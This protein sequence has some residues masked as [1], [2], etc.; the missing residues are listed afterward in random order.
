MEETENK[1][2]LSKYGKI[3]GFLALEILA[4][5]AFGLGNSFIFVSI[6]SFILL[7]VS[8]IV[9]IRQ[10]NKDG[11]TTFAFMLFPLFI[12]GILSALSYMNKD[13]S[14]DLYNLS[15][16]IP[17][18]LACI[19]ACGYFM[20][21]NK[22]FKIR[23]ALVV[24]YSAIAVI[25]LINLFATLIE[26]TPFYTLIYRSKYIY[27]DGRPSSTPISE[28]AFALMGF[29]MTE[30]STQYFSLFPTVLLSAVVP[31]FFMKYKEEKKYFLI[32]AA[33]A[34]IGFI[35]LVLTPNKWTIITD[36]LVLAILVVFLFVAKKKIKEKPMKI[37]LIV[38]GSIVLLTFIV[39]YIN[40]Q[41]DAKG[42]VKSIQD[43][44]NSIPLFRKVFTTNGLI[45]NYNAILDGLFGDCRM[46]GYPLFA[47]E[48]QG[49]DYPYGLKGSGSFLFDNVLTSGL[50]GGLFFLFA[51]VLAFRRMVMYY[52]TCDDE[53]SDKVAIWAIT[54]SFFGYSLINFDMTPYAFKST[55]MP[56]FESGVFIVVLFLMSYCFAKS[57]NTATPKEAKVEEVEN[58]EKEVTL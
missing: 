17:F 28:I 56:I 29:E 47:T 44:L 21:I 8:L 31:L 26:F 16:F 30:V 32:Y 41:K 53:L 11:I 57:A 18:C 3:V 33:C 2:S 52:K 4:I 1:S 49:Y 13:S 38:V 22:S 54:L 45:K 55:I 42:I 43:A 20:S 7:V 27:Y 37:A 40:A 5:I 39:M 51:L 23:H 12:Y 58:N 25:T 46:F 35:S 10:V 15:I 48:E 34:A 6:L 14:F 19:S 9:T 36:F 24:I 50:F